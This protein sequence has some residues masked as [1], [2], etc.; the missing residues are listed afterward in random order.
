MSLQMDVETE[1]VA[2]CDSSQKDGSED[3]V[4]VQQDSINQTPTNT[5]RKRL[6]R[7]HQWKKN[8]RK[9]KRAR[10][11]DYVS[12]TGAMVAARNVV[13]SCEVNCHCPLKCS[14]KIN[15]DRQNQLRQQFYEMS[16]W[17]V[18]T[19]YIC[20]QVKVSKI[21]K[22]YTKTAE[23]RRQNSKY[24]YLPNADGH[25][26]RVCKVFFQGVLSLSDGRIARATN[27]KVDGV[28][29]ADQRGRHSP[30]NKTP[31]N[32]SMFVYEFIQQFQTYTSH[33]SRAKNPNRSYLSPELN[34]NKMYEM[35]REH[36]NEVRPVRNPVSQHIFRQIFNEQFNLSFHPPHK[37]TCKSCD[38]FNAQIKACVSDFEKQ[39]LQRS[40]QLHQRKA[41]SARDSLRFDAEHCKTDRAVSVIT[42]DLEKTLPTP[43]LSTGVCYYK[44]QLWTYNLGVHN[45]ADDQG[46]MYMWNESV[47]SRGPD[48]IGSALMYHINKYITTAEDLVIYTDCCGGQ[49]RNFK[50]AMIWN[51]IV[52]NQKYSVKCIHHKF[53]LS[54]HTYLPN[55][56]DFGLIEKNKRFHSDIF[57]PH[58]W[59]RVVASARKNK[60]FVVTELDQ[61]HFVSTGNLL[62]MCV[63]RKMNADKCKV[64]WLKIQWIFFTVDHPNVMFF[65]YTLSDDAEFYSVDFSKKV[66]G[67]PRSVNSVSLA[68]LYPDGKSIQR[69]KLLDLKELLKYI[70]AVHHSFYKGLKSEQNN[71]DDGAGGSD[72]WTE[73]DTD[74][75]DDV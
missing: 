3:V 35:Y 71:N 10:G 24:Y 44:R 57:V 47:A 53:L 75:D 7:P 59:V 72:I 8:I 34:L 21:K 67:R 17:S 9:R 16:D 62:Q 27:Q 63:N 36:C 38:A 58:D 70:P 50:I 64:E 31:E 48:E 74:T 19:A 20:A 66:R 39:H 1:S 5:C 23:S 13:I 26:V 33:Y 49:N 29:Q 55:D 51:Y 32:D 61:S 22:R 2:S 60:P 65:K 42:F 41:D 15:K 4:Q 52:Q 69:L 68:P 43:L 28:P 37:D 40:L 11:E 56:Q 6:R 18:Q 14:E 45:M 25:D 12:T 30:H 73:S 46:Y 54:G